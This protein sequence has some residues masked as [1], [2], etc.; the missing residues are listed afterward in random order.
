VRFGVKSGC[1]DLR[2]TKINFITRTILDVC[3]RNN[4]YNAIGSIVWRQ[5]Y[6]DI[7]TA[8]SCGQ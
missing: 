3:I 1:C 4:S 6:T 2:G 7:A 5:L 8:L